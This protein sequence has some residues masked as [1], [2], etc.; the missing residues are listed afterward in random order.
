LAQEIKG[1]VEHLPRFLKERKLEGVAKIF[2]KNSRLLLELILF[3][4]RIDITYALLT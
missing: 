2:F 3:K 4:C 1:A